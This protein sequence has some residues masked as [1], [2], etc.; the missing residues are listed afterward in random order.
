MKHKKCLFSAE[1]PD[2]SVYFGKTHYTET[3]RIHNDVCRNKLV[4]DRMYKNKQVPKIEILTT[5]KHDEILFN[6]EKHLI[7][8]YKE[9]GYNIINKIG[10]VKHAYGEEI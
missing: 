10:A 4:L 2:K 8:I 7:R 9:D 3:H 5:Q 1:F 6:I